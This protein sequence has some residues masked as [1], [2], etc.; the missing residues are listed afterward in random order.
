MN[1]EDIERIVREAR[2]CGERPYLRHADL[3]G[4]DLRGA[5]LSGANLRGADLRGADLCGAD[6][7][8]AD[9]SG[10]NLKGAYL[11]VANLTV[12]NLTDAYLYDADLARANLTGA[13]LTG[14]NLTGAY[15]EDAVL[16]AGVPVI[17]NI[18]AAI[19]AAID[20]GGEL[21]MGSWHSCETTHCRAGWAIILAG[22]AGRTLEVRAGPDAAGAL[23]Y[24]AS[25]SHPTPNWFA[26]NEDAMRDLRERAARL[27]NT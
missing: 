3:C 16:P 9:L 23:I 12:A 25:G 10:A 19:L 11:T 2:E 8:G 17:P 22:D 20:A 14:A 7:R 18:D 6:L 27:A 24:A 21:E 1:R 4:A 15:L 26:N 13:R 5:D